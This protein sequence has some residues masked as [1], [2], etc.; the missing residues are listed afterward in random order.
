MGILVVVFLFM[1]F[2]LYFSKVFNSH[3]L[4]KRSTPKCNS[5]CNN[6]SEPLKIAVAAL[7][8]CGSRGYSKQIDDFH[9]HNPWKYW[10]INC[11][12]RT[13]WQPMSLRQLRRLGKSFS[14]TAGQE[15]PYGA[16]ARCQGP[17]VLGT[18]NW[19]VIVTKI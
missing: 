18:H 13:V 7:I 12:A 8:I 5:R 14:L 11:F 15:S 9:S 17:C 1:S 16:T 4:Q 6:I 3:D 19:M 2:K 10:Q